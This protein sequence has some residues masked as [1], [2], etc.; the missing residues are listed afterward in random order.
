MIME[1]IRAELLKRKNLEKERKGLRTEEHFRINSVSVFF[2][3]LKMKVS[4][5]ADPKK[6]NA[7][8]Q[9]VVDEKKRNCKVLTGTPS[10]SIHSS[11]LK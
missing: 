9:E 6:S 5:S 1:P 4:E 3:R 10:I 11:P 7:D 2:L 8:F